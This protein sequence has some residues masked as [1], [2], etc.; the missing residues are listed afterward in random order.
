MRF[1]LLGPLMVADSSGQPVAVGGPRLRIL[2]AALLLHAGNPVPVGELVE[3]VWDGSPPPRAVSSLRSYIRRLRRALG[4]D[5]ARI[6][7]LDPGY[8]IRAARPELDVL[9]FEALCL[10]TRAALRAGKWADASAT[11]ARALGLWRAAP[12]LD[13]SSETLRS[14][15]VPRLEGLRLQMLEDRFDAG[16]RLGHHQE[17]VP[18]LLEMTAQH[19]LQERFHAQLMLA[20][21]TTGRRAQALHAYQEARRTLVDQLGIE[22]G[23]ELRDIHRRILA[24]EVVDVDERADA[25]LPGNAPGANMAGAA[26]QGRTGHGPRHLLPDTALFTGRDREI[27]ALLALAGQAGSGASPG[28]V[29]ISTIDG[30]GGVGKTALA[31]HAAHRLG[32]RYPDGQ[33]FIDLAGFTAGMQPLEPSQALAELLRDLGT[34]PQ[35]IPADPQ[36]R[37]A[38]YRDRL[39]GTRTL[40]VLDNAASEDQVRPLLP[41]TGSCLVLITSRRRLAA[42]DDALPLPLDVLAP[43]EAVTLLRRAARLPAAAASHGDEE[44]RLLEQVAGLCGRLP[45]AL[46][47][48]AAL[49]RAHGRAWTLDHLAARLAAAPPDRELTPFDDGTRNLT[50]LFDV[51]Y[52]VLPA[53]LQQFYRCLGVLPGPEIDGYAAAALIAGDPEQAEAHLGQL[54]GCSLLEAASP[55]RYRMHDLL[56]AHARTLAAVDYGSGQA[57]RA[58]LYHHYQHTARRAATLTTPTPRPGP[59]GPA[60]AHAPPLPGADSAWAWLR[61]E[62]ANLLAAIDDAG[63]RNLGPDLIILTAGL[64]TVLYADGPWPQAAILHQTAAAVAGR[65]GDH[66]GQAGALADLGAVRR[67]TGDFPGAIDAFTQAL[68]TYRDLGDGLG[69]AAALIGLGTVRQLTGDYPGA[70]SALTQALHTYR[71]IG[72]RPGQAHALTGLGNARQLTGDYPGATSAL[73]QALHTY[74]D[75][76]DHLGQAAALTVLGD[77]RRATGDHPGAKDAFTQALHT[78]RDIGHRLGQAHTLSRLAE[79]RRLTGDYPGAISALTQALNTYRDL[80]DHLGQAAALTVLG[81]VRLATGDHPGATSALTQALHTFRHLES[82]SNEAWALNHYAAAVRAGGDLTRAL[83]L[84]QQAL[85]M[86]RELGQPDDEAIALEGTGECL[87]A[88]GRTAEGTARLRQALDLYQRLGMSAHTERLTAHLAA[89]ARPPV[90]ETG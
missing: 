66:R 80:G 87:L 25:V 33:L 55:G 24:G 84:Y 32:G 1:A 43:A 64:A 65:L 81:N 7:A 30:M 77:V 62:R 78:Y 58:R 2:L 75:L 13:V 27:G 69:Q 21:A 85:A 74:R 89:P 10:D 44:T 61:A 72:H 39:H 53:G 63:R 82:R 50:A 79:V 42:L 88:Q 37:A 14:E 70:T 16:L 17:L 4:D 38:F 11:A 48:A 47:I 46:L 28:A 83:Q 67:R 40:I 20:L 60:P 31:L 56:R 34:P 51:S 6:V 49:L 26:A 23:P 76:G 36:A 59:G 15:F 86:N 19:P 90:P 12:L 41:G 5:A 8:L 3:M 71:D 22:P 52:H 18:Q 35:L 73:T 9:E 29:V 57:A 68:N 54:A 45:L